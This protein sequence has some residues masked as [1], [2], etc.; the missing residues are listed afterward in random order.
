MTSRLDPELP[1]V[2]FDERHPHLCGRSVK[3][4]RGAVPTFRLVRSPESRSAMF[5][6][7]LSAAHIIN[8][9]ITAVASWDTHGGA[10][11]LLPGPL[12]G[13]ASWSLQ[14]APERSPA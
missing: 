1:S 11:A 8:R 12:G 3:S 6:P 4:A 2:G 14:R 5:A 10:M 13:V 7:H 9:R